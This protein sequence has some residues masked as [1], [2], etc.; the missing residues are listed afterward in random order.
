MCVFCVQ[1]IQSSGS[2]QMNQFWRSKPKSCLLGFGKSYS[3]GVFHKTIDQGHIY[4]RCDTMKSE[5]KLHVLSCTFPLKNIS[6]HQNHHFSEANDIGDG[7]W[8]GFLSIHP[9]S[10]H[11]FITSYEVKFEGKNTDTFYYL[12]IITIK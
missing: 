4:T 7:K 3:K 2:F 5:H 8:E 12:T 6:R 11:Q 9:K 1:S 10:L